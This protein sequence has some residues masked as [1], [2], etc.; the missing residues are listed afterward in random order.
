MPYG[1]LEQASLAWKAS[2]VVFR[3]IGDHGLAETFARLRDHNLSGVDYTFAAPQR[4]QQ[5]SVSARI[6]STTRPLQAL[7]RVPG[8]SYIVLREYARE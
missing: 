3:S 4:E 8:A 6:R 2:K 7:Q 1:H 5:Q